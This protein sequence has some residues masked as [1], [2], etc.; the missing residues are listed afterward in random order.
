MRSVRV[1]DGREEGEEHKDGRE[2]A[3]G[4]FFLLRAAKT[5]APAAVVVMRRLQ[6]PTGK[7]RE[8]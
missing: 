8:G 2:R 3:T 7:Q 6:T 1:R 5:A 4:T